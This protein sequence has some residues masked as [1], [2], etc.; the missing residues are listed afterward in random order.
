MN[1]AA[2]P[3][4]TDFIGPTEGTVF[5]RQMQVRYT[6][7]LS[8]TM[9]F[10]VALEN[11]ETAG[12][13]NLSPILI[14]HD[15]DQLPDLIARLNFK[16]D[17]GD[18]SVAGVARQ[19]RIAAGAAAEDAAGFGLV[20][21]GR[22]KVGASDD[23]R[24]SLGG[25]EG[26]GRYFGLNFAPDASDTPTDFEAVSML[27]GFVA[28]RHMWDKDWRSTLSYAFQNVDNKAGVTAPTSSDRVWSAAANLF[29]SPAKGVDLGVEYRYAER[30]LLNGQSGDLNRLHL[31]A[32]RSF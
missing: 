3:E 2:L 31:M 26:V 23:L 19:L 7:T 13:T 25:G 16:N 21:S 14:E 15:D 27:A 9:T 1:V 4:T 29:Y 20:A 28:Y 24:F 30:E 8:Q 5:A 12:V 17:L 32:R 22:I 18:F 6:G 10:Q 11:P